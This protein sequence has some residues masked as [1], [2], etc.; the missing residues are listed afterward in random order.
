MPKKHPLSAL[1]TAIFALS[2]SPGAFADGGNE[3]DDT[4][5]EHGVLDVD[6]DHVATMV[7]GATTRVSSTRDG[8]YEITLANG[9]VVDIK[10]R[11]NTR[12]HTRT[13][14]S[15]TTTVDADGHLHL[16]TADGY[17]MTVEA[18]AHSETETHSLLALNGL[19]SI[20]ASG[21]RLTAT[22]HDGSVLSLEADYEVS[23]PAASGTARYTESSTGVDIDYADGTR[24][25]FHGAAADVNQLRAGAQSL[26]YTVSFNSDG[27]VN[28]TGRGENHHLRLSPSLTQGLITQPGLR[29]Q[30]SKVVMQYQNGL[31]QE[32]TVLQ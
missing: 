22:R 12:V 21:G 8:N 10:P 7:G 28:A 16:Q 13:T 6:V 14:G 17:E 4:F 32:I 18:A 11:G 20:S 30:D 26:G 1:I 27:S 24:Q 5:S 9:M 3:A 31:E 23:H 25:H 15:T 19:N 29:I 2:L